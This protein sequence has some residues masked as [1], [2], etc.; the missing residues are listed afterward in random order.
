MGWDGWMDGWVGD[1]WFWVEEGGEMFC[2]NT[3]ERRLF[4]TNLIQHPPPL[5]WARICGGSCF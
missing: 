4:R 5:A 1:V 3:P 2:L